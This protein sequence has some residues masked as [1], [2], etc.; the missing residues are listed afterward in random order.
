MTRRADLIRN[1]LCT[2]RERRVHDPVVSGYYPRLVTGDGVCLSAVSAHPTS[3]I[4]LL[5]CLLLS[6]LN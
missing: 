1:M 2:C 6:I 3:R 4:V 5:S